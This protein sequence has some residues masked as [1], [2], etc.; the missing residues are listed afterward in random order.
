MEKLRVEYMEKCNK[1]FRVFFNKYT[2]IT[3][4]LQESVYVI[5]E[6]TAEINKDRVFGITRIQIVEGSFCRAVLRFNVDTTPF[7]GERAIPRSLKTRFFTIPQY[8][9]IEF[10]KILPNKCDI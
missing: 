1:D 2:S 7:K 9:F 5:A 6:S 8:A 4:L 10:G 3:F